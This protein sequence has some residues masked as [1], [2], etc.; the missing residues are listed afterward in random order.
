MCGIEVE[1]ELDEDVFFVARRVKI[2]RGE[3][4][5]VDNVVFWL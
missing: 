1:C 5:I 4:V 2:L 3:R